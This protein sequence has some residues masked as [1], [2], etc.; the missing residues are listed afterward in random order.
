MKE[1]ILVFII[2][3]INILL[4]YLYHGSDF[5][6]LVAVYCVLFAPFILFKNNIGLM[7]FNI[8]IFLKILPESFGRRLNEIKG[9]FFLPIPLIVFVTLF[10]KKFL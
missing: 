1:K 5:A 7:D 8:Y 6:L 3:F 4:A 2:S 9:W 10:I